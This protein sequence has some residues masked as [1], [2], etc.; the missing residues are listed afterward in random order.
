MR[1]PNLSRTSPISFRNSSAATPTSPH[2][3][4]KQIEGTVISVSADQVFL[5][6]G[7]KTEGVLPR[8]RLRE[9][10]RGRQ[11][12]PDASPSR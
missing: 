11:A 2:P 7:Y 5:D 8:T 12:G 10:R 1:H 3:G 4:Q 6:I 9:Q